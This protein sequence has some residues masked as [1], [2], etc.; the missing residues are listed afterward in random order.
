MSRSEINRRNHTTSNSNS[1]TIKLTPF[2]FASSSVACE[3]HPDRNEDSMVIDQERGLAAVFDGVGGSAAGEV[4]S[5]IAQRTTHEM[6]KQILQERQKGRKVQSILEDGSAIDLCAELERIIL[7]AD[8]RVRV[9]GKQRAGTDDLAT[10]VAIAVLSRNPDHKSYTMTYAHVGDS[11]IYMLP[12]GGSLKRLTS[13]DGLLAKLV[14]NQVVNDAD[15][16]HIDQ[17]MRAEELSE[18][19]FSYFRLRGGI[20]Q[21]L[22]GPIQPVIH[23]SQVAIVPGDRV[24]L[25]TDGIHDNLT[26]KEIEEILRTKARSTSA[27]MLVECSIER[28]HEERQQTIRS[29]PDDM[30]AIVMTCRF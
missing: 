1:G 15:A 20:T 28:S 11:R 8:E 17:A 9:D 16:L 12:Y 18:M 27:R 21:A 4:A 25:C 7:E 6:W 5:R 2:E 29:K 3:R 10:T 23:S 30:S 22:G 14:E 26:D 24:L 19:E 13:D